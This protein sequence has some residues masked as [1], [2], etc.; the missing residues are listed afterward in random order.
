MAEWRVTVDRSRCM[1]S[2]ICTAMAG[3]YFL[4]DGERSRPA[5]EG[6]PP[7]EAV[8]DAADSCPAGA[9]TVTAADGEVVGPRD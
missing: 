4:M 9:I 1:G 3:T 6:V 2:G 5:A 8:L 7:G